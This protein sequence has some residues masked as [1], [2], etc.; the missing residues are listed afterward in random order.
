MSEEYGEKWESD[1]PLPETAIVDDEIIEEGDAQ[2][3]PSADEIHE[4]L[5]ANGLT[6]QCKTGF[7][8]V[9]NEE[10]EWV[11][12]TDLSLL[13]LLEFERSANMRDMVKG[14]ESVAADAR[15]HQT[16]ADV[17]QTVVGGILQT[18]PDAMVARGQ[19]AAQEMARAQA[20]A[21]LA[22][23]IGA[24]GKILRPR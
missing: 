14:A 8:V 13:P 1:H 19:R 12:N 22:S 4:S 23:R 10:G 21:D 3:V 2:H 16:V 11:A 15:H 18:L 20:D 17:A 9:L 6:P 5:R 7:F 24:A